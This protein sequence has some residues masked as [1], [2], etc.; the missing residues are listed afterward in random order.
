[1]SM[2][3]GRD[4]YRIML[5]LVLAHLAAERARRNLKGRMAWH[6]LVLLRNVIAIKISGGEA[7]ETNQACELRAK[8][9]FGFR[10]LT[11]RRRPR[12]FPNI[13]VEIFGHGT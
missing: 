2:Q 9:P 7:H 1:M 10:G 6:C 3:V 13:L 11:M 5:T 8:H 4:V 12:L